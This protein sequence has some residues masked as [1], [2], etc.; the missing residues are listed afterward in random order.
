MS[1]EQGANGKTNYLK[2]I[3]GLWLIQETRRAYR[4]AGA[5][6]S[7]NDLEQLARAAEPFTCLIDPGRTFAFHP[8]RSAGTDP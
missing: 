8:R 7:Y 2:N 5:E 3:S 1:N 4:R 6:Y